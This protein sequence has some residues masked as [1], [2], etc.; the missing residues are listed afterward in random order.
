MSS[1]FSSIAP[2]G[3]CPAAICPAGS[4][5]PACPFGFTPSC[6]SGFVPQ[7]YSGQPRCCDDVSCTALTCVA[8]T[9]SCTTDFDCGFTACADVGG[10]MKACTDTKHCVNNVCVAGAPATQSCMACV[11]T[12]QCAV[13]G[14]DVYQCSDGI[15][16]D[17]DGFTDATDPGCWTDPYNSGSYNPSGNNE[18]SAST[19]CT[20]GIDNDQDGTVDSADPG[21][22]DD[23]NNISSPQYNPTLLYENAGLTFCEDGSDND[24]DG[25]I[26]AQD[27]GCDN[28]QDYT[29]DVAEPPG[30]HAT[31]ACNDG[32]DNGDGDN[33]YDQNDPG[34]KI[35]GVW[36]PT[37]DNETD[38]LPLCG[39]GY[40][41][42]GDGFVDAGRVFG[43]FVGFNRDPSCVSAAGT[44]ENA[45]HNPR[46]E[47]GAETYT[48]CKAITGWF[49]DPDNNFTD[50]VNVLI[51]HGG[52]PGAGGTLLNGAGTAANLGS[53]DPTTQQH[54]GGNAAH[55]FSYSVSSAYTTPGTSHT[56]Y[57]LGKN[58]GS[59]GSDLGIGFT[60]TCAQP[61]AYQCSDGVDNDGDGAIDLVDNDCFDQFDDIEAPG[62]FCPANPGVCGQ[63]DARILCIKAA[64]GASS[65]ALVSN[66][67]GQGMDGTVGVANVSLKRGV[68]L[69]NIANCGLEAL[70]PGNFTSPVIEN[71]IRMAFGN[72]LAVPSVFG[73]NAGKCVQDK[74]LYSS[75]GVLISK[76]DN[77]NEQ[78]LAYKFNER[79]GAG[80]TTYDGHPVTPGEMIHGIAD[81]GI[82]GNAGW[83]CRPCNGPGDVSVQ[84][85][86]GVDNDNDGL[87]DGG[88]PGCVNEG[89][90]T[91]QDAD[92]SDA[93]T[94]CQDGTDDDGDGLVDSADPG[95]WSDPGNPNSAYT[96]QGNNEASANAE[97][98]DGVDNDGDG[99]S[100]AMDPG[101]DGPTD[102]T[103][104]L[105]EAYPGN[106]E[107]QRIMAWPECSN[108]ADDD[109]DGRIDA[110]DQGCR[111]PDTYDPTDNEEQDDSPQCADGR[112]NDG[113]G[114]VDTGHPWG[115]PPGFDADFACLSDSKEESTDHDPRGQLN[116]GSTCTTLYGWACDPDSWDKSV[117]VNIHVDSPTGPTFGKQD[118]SGTNENDHGIPLYCGGNEKHAFTIDVPQEYTAAGTHTYYV[119]FMNFA[120]GKNWTYPAPVTV[121]CT[122]PQVHLC[123]NGADDDGDGFTDYPD[124]PGCANAYDDN[125]WDPLCPNGNYS[126][127]GGFTNANFLGTQ[128]ALSASSSSVASA[129]K[130]VTATPA[131]FIGGGG[132]AASSSSGKKK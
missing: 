100:D 107:E 97:C 111:Q 12:D 115:N 21:C 70:A 116:A 2:Q 130:G 28:F 88:D 47:A 34:C 106:A 78:F 128:Q 26:D 6:T 132:K 73:P 62:P 89:A 92:E 27:P 45:D 113:D 44:A 98:A 4:P 81:N 5:Y 15:D 53:P 55:G 17:N 57:V 69:Q 9:T 129:G 29:E 23:P 120:D 79:V 127:A 103:E 87:V 68:L 25:V 33:V 36:K 51:Y 40:D 24:G 13:V 16:N 31:P 90:Y 49:C 32:V 8:T 105:N 125:E 67:S 123:S 72:Q 109:G 95:C 118:A 1:S 93:T 60:M 122:A 54:C 65:V 99:L 64:L 66:P 126:S 101:C 94:Q 58:A 124:D 117:T 30:A 110:E 37:D 10:E 77:C 3:Y 74:P 114:L 86:D 52:A 112:D 56:Y 102:Y 50:S 91:P 76:D 11:C 80:V 39:N 42:D 61:H 59:Q 46:G 84:C 71:A 121:T 48:D 63:D 96:P 119:E 82:F 108:G 104:Y 20:D 7:C 38:G 85:A 19:E 22:W 18:L 83:M 131:N 43:P 35:G 41:D 14:T 75:A